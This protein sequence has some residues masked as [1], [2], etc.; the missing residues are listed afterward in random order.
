MA[1]LKIW[2]D[3]VVAVVY[4]RGIAVCCHW[5][6]P[7]D[8]QSACCSLTAQ[9]VGLLLALLMEANQLMNVL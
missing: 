7:L 4:L 5:M 6:L 8:V 3:L 1:L 9:E 2:C